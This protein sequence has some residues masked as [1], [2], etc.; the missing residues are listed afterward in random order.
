MFNS[1]RFREKVQKETKKITRWVYGKRKGDD[2][3]DDEVD[4]NDSRIYRDSEG[5]IIPI[6]KSAKNGTLNQ[7]SEG[8]YDL[9][10]P[11]EGG[12]RDELF[13]VRSSNDDIMHHCSFIFTETVNLQA[14]IFHHAPEIVNCFNHK[15]QK[16]RVDSNK[17]WFIK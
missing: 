2:D 3:D 13:T 6:F 10:A 15:Q 17:H 7:V 9:K 4:H 16:E 8:T 5:N 12:V 1:R 14:A 11:W